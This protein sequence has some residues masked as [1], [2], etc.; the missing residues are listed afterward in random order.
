MS[1]SGSPL[2][3]LSFLA[4]AMGPWCFATIRGELRLRTYAPDRVHQTDNCSMETGRRTAVLL[5][6][7]ASR[8]GG[9]PIT[10]ELPEVVFRR[11]AHASDGSSRRPDRLTALNFTYGAMVSHRTREGSDP[12]EAVN[13][14]TLISALRLLRK[15]EDHEVAPFVLNWREPTLPTGYARADEH[16]SRELVEINP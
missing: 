6:A 2:P 3:I 10:C 14:E 11:P 1:R 15:R 13:I 16:T 4:N 12:H 8:D 5:G 7:G 9:L